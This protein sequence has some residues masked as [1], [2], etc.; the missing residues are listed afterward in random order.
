VLDLDVGISLLARLESLL[1]SEE[2]ERA[3]RFQFV[4]ERAR[5]VAAR[6]MLRQVLAFYLDRDPA[7]LTFKQARFG[8]P[9]LPPE[10]DSLRFN[11]SGSEGLALVAVRRDVEI[12]IDVERVRPFPDAEA[13]AA[14]LFAPAELSELSKLPETQREHRFFEAWVRKEAVAK[15]TGVGLSQTPDADSTTAW[16][17]QLPPPQPQYVAALAAAAPIGVVRYGTWN[18]PPPR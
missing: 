3:W 6:G 2:V 4:Q 10:M 5:F 17:T 8:K 15:M 9:S 1:S 14:R 16:V 13:L 18:P 12:G 11:A 7:S